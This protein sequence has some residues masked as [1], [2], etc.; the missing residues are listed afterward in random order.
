MDRKLIAVAAISGLAV[1]FAAGVAVGQNAPTEN[2]GVTVSPPT[3]VD[4]SKEIDTVAGRQLRLR[5]VTIEPGGVVAM[6][7]HKGRPTVAYLVQGDIVEHVDDGAT[8]D[9]AA[10]TAWTEAN[11]ISHWSENKGD[12]PAVIIAVDVFKP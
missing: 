11:G 8:H 1:A 10:G 5:A 9:H 7:S 6:H 4:L 2:K 3:F 12:K